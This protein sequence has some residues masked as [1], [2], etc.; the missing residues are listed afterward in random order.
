[1]ELYKVSEKIE[2]RSFWTL[3]VPDSF[4]LYF[5]LFYIVSF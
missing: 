5:I 1:M 3:P 4:N 2:T